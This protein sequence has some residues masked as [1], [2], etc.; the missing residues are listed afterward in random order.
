MG[1][2]AVEIFIARLPNEVF[3]YLRD[4]TN[5]AKWH[6]SQSIS[7][8]PGPARV[9]TKVHKIRKTPNGE[10]R[11]TIEITE[12][13][14]TGRRGVDLAIAGSFRGTKGNWQVT[15]ENGGSKVRLVAEM[16]ATGLWRLILPLINS[17][18]RKEL[19]AEFANLKK[20]LESA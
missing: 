19:P 6:V 13:E 14:E 1:T 11:F 20:A 3:A 12:M 9:G 2:V 16:K 18:A 15:S 17:T 7:E 4:Y 10:Q 8:P 5:E